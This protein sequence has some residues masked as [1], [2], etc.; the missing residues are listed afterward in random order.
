[1]RPKLKFKHH[2]APPDAMARCSNGAL[3]DPSEYSL[4]ARAIFECGDDRLAWLIN[5]IAVSIGVQ[6][7]TGPAYEIFEIGYGRRSCRGHA[8]CEGCRII[9]QKC[10][11]PD[12]TSHSSM[13]SNPKR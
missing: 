3:L 13:T 6:T 1:M 10:G 8:G 7:N 4:A 2:K 9:D 5:V 12:G 11:P